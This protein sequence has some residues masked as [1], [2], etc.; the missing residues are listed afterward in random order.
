LRE[1][2][3]E[4]FARFVEGLVGADVYVTVDLDCLRAEEA[5]TNWESGRF[6]VEEVAWAIELLG[7]G[8]LIVAADICGAWSP[9]RYARWKQGFAATIDHPKLILPEP[10]EIRRR[11][12]AALRRL[13]P[14]LCQRD[15]DHAEADQ[16]RADR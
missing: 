6:G 12:E 10:A 4:K 5:V 16:D 8:N 11:N 13:L 7:R 2:L 15:Q 14:A 3:R 9:A 1:D